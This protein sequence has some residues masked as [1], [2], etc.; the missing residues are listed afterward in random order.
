MCFS[1]SQ[2]DGPQPL[3]LSLPF[4]PCLLLGVGSLLTLVSQGSQGP[5]VGL[6]RFAY[7]GKGGGWEGGPSFHT[8]PRAC[9]MCRALI[10]P[11]WVLKA[12]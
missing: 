10:L 7:R 3:P 6:G 4:P 8:S 11:Q 12:L 2:T 1:L 9:S 5:S